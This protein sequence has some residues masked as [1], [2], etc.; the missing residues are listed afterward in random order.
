MNSRALL[1]ALAAVVL[2]G[3][4]GYLGYR[5]VTATR[6]TLAPAVP[7]ARA[8]GTPPSSAVPNA[9]PALKLPETL[10]DIHLTDLQGQRRALR[11]FGRRPLIVNFWATWC[12]PCRREMPLLTA[13]RR[14]YRDPQL[15]IVG[16]A[17]D[18]RDS[19]S[20]FL[21]KNPLDYP[22]LVGE[23]DGMEAARAFGMQMVL[24]FSVFVDEQDRIIAMK[25]GELHRDEA[26]AIL[27]AMRSLRTGR[28]SIGDTRARITRQLG[29]LAAV[30]ATHAAAAAGRPPP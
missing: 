10:P 11:D 8:G 25:V 19:V 17:V 15:E 30:R 14:E 23:E 13:L 1:A 7:I 3:S 24:P 9:E 16:I 29:L 28:V 4:A 26:V 27:D 12:E 20:A 6:P 22:Q 2:G 5:W 18:F 21:R